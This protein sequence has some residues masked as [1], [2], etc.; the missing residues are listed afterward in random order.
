MSETNPRESDLILGGQILPPVNAAILGGLAGV[1]QRLESESIAERL[2]ALNN[3]VAYG[4]DGIDLAL[5]S[6]SDNDDKVRRLA[7]RLLRDRFGEA[8][9]K[10]FINHDVASYFL[11]I[12]DWNKEEYYSGIGIA[13]PDNNAY[14]RE[15][16]LPGMWKKD[17][18]YQTKQFKSL[19]Q[20]SSA[21][22]MQALILE[23]VENKL[24]FFRFIFESI[25]SN[26]TPLSNLKALQIGD[27]KIDWEEVDLENDEFDRDLLV[28]PKNDRLYQTDIS[29]LLILFPNLEYLNV[30]GNY[31]EYLS[32]NNLA[33]KQFCAGKSIKNKL[34]TLVIGD[35]DVDRTISN[36]SPTSFPELEHFEIW[37]NDT[38]DIM[39]TIQAI[40]P[41]L[42]KKAT[43]KL[44]YLALCNCQVS[45]ALIR[46]VIRTPVIEKLDVLDFRSGSMMDGI[47]QYILDCQKIRNLKLLNISDNYLTER[48]IERLRQLPCKIEAANQFQSKH[49]KDERDLRFS[50]YSVSAE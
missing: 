13:D 31:H 50:R 2:Q 14:Y 11:K 6:L 45:E 16:Y 49:A 4:D 3:A 8:G 18:D 34:K 27:R 24:D 48:G 39:P 37:F 30:Y 19:L 38:K 41:I 10:A 44:K 26:N 36:I 15:V 22:R 17:E 20:S 40:S 21:N 28:K 35:A 33:L 46:A 47:I 12:D 1:K 42:S 23:A 7:K 43:P 32:P 9:K 5:R 29:S 25:Q